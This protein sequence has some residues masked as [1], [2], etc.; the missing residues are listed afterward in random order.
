[1]RCSKC[2]GEWFVT[3]PYD[4]EADA[5]Y[6]ELEAVFAEVPSAAAAFATPAERAPVTKRPPKPFN[7]KPFKIAVPA[8]A[9][10]WLAV[11]FIAYF[12]SW[13]QAPVF[14][15]IYHA[16]GVLPTDGLVFSDVHME[17][18]QEGSKTRFILAGSIRNEASAAR[19]VPTVRVSLRGAGDKPIWGREYPVNTELKAGEVYPFRITNAETSFASSVTGIVVDLGNSLQLLVR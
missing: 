18:V 17:R 12:P 16:L 5:I 13:S 14:S 3:P 2:A 8:I 4:P 19:I 11:S 1:M 9:A 10:L 6:N 7:A 15:G